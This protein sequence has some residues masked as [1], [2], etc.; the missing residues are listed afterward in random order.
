MK[1]R[2]EIGE[3]L[4][5]VGMEGK[6]LEFKVGWRWKRSGVMVYGGVSMMMVVGVGK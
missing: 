2:M 6:D 5:M 3:C 1:M 4:K